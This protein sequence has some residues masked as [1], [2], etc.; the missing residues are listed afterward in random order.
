M[1]RRFTVGEH[2]IDVREPAT[3][4]ALEDRFA[5]RRREALAVND[6]NATQAA[7]ARFR[8]ETAKC[9][10]RL[11]R[12]QAVQIELCLN[13]PTSASQSGEHIGAEPGS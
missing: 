6:A 11:M 1:P 2:V 3:H 12:R 4:F 7:A 8:Q 13:D 10:V 5:V 9:F